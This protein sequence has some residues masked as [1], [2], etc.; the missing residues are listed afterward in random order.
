MIP[1]EIPIS[2]VNNTLKIE[3]IKLTQIQTNLYDSLINYNTG[4]LLFAPNKIT[5]NFN[6]SYTES[7]KGYEGDSILE[8]KIY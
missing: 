6:F 8:L 7:E 1:F 5:L 4:L 2:I 3:N